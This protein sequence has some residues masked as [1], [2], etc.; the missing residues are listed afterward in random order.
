MAFSIVENPGVYALL[1]GSGISRSAEIPTGWDIT[2]DLV[3]RVATAEGA[4]GETDWA[5]WHRARF[6]T[7]PGYS[8]LL[9][10]LSITP[11][12]RRSIL[13]R[14]IEPSADD[15]EARRRVPT[16]AHHSIA[17][18]VRDGFVRVVITTN[19][20]RLLETALSAVGVEPVVIKSVDDLAGSSPLP[21]SRCF[22]LKVHGDYLD[23]RILNTEDELASYPIEYDRL[24]DRILD[25]YGLIVSGWSGEWDP[26]LRAAIVRAPNRRFPTWWAA[27]GGPAPAAQDLIAARAATV[28]HI[29]DA[30]T[31]FTQLGDAVDVLAKSRRPSPDTIEILLATTKR[32]LASP[33]RRINLA[34]AL[35][36]QVERVVERIS[37][38]DL[39]V[40]VPGV[41]NE[42]VL[43]RWRA[44]EGISEPLARMAG[45]I[46]RWGDG[47]EFGQ[48]EDALKGLVAAKGGNGNVALLGLTT[49]P[50]YLFYLTYALGL[51]KAERWQELFRWLSLQISRQY[52]EPTS[53][54]NSLFMSFWDDFEPDWWKMWP[55]LERHRTPWAAHLIANIV[56]WSRDYGLI[57][58]AALDNYLTTE[59]LGGFAALTPQ[60][61]NF[62]LQLQQ[63]TWMPHGQT[64]WDGHA[65]KQILS[66]LQSPELQPKLLAAGFCKG[67]TNHWAGVLNNIDHLARRVGW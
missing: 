64:M 27:R 44:V 19:F 67:S 36:D 17:R 34:D 63:F 55:G 46:G 29:D 12:E 47:S 28:V 52:R 1:L 60:D 31:F 54:V 11:A 41:T 30:D 49:Y 16:R 42:I 58:G 25:E 21:H 51:T 4:T 14:Y 59:L 65:R 18:L 45:I 26:A 15:L 24:L 35:A 22:L 32:N 62:L 9:D 61:E 53:A 43:D 6:G 23:N 7:D 10:A 57:G 48:M 66:R 37:G 33:D 39:P 50:A 40:S 56:P 2:L 8:S 13:H 38:P 20:D 3:R 5:A